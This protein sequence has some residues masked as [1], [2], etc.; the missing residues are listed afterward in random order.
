[1]GQLRHLPP[2]PH[3]TTRE[4]AALSTPT[5]RTLRRLRD[6]GYTAAVVERWNPHAK[7]RQDLFGFIDVLAVG[8]CGTLAVQACNYGDVARRIEKITNHENVGAVRE[9]GWS[10]EVHGWHKVNGRYKCRVV[11]VS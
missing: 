4:E 6:Q 11:D 5:Q 9:A 3:P 1:M 2:Y 10:I 8:P 7:I